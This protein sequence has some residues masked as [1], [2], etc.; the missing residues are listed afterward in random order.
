MNTLE[1]SKQIRDLVQAGTPV[2][3]MYV[4]EYAEEKNLLRIL[5]R[6][7]MR[8]PMDRSPQHSFAT[9]FA[10]VSPDDLATI[11]AQLRKMF[12]S[13]PHVSEAA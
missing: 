12:V 13:L 7:T 5:L 10:H 11:R 8:S 4:Y 1:I 9:Q 6:Q 3:G 2:P